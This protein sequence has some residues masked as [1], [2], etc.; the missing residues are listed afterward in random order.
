MQEAR[1]RGTQSVFKVCVATFYTVWA[2][3]RKDWDEGCPGCHSAGSVF[4]KETYGL[5]DSGIFF[6]GETYSSTFRGVL[7]YISLISV[8]IN[9]GW[10][11]PSSVGSGGISS[12]SRI[13]MTDLLEVFSFDFS[14]EGCFLFLSF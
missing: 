11:V 12:S 6:G 5:V 8:C 7:V 1:D 2:T 14:L 4:F 3:V 9:V 13:C 10:G